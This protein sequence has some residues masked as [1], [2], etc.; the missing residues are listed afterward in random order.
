MTEPS[1]GRLLRE[2]R[3]RRA[4]SQDDVARA[5]ARLSWQLDQRAADVTAVLLQVGRGEVARQVL[6]T[7]INGLEPAAV[8][9]RTVFLA[10][11]AGSHLIG[12]E[13]DV[14][15][16]CSIAGDVATAL[17]HAGYATGTE[18]RHA[19]RADLRPWDAHPAVTVL[20]ERFTALGS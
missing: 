5:L 2:Q 4:L 17:M 11:I 14:E 1:P 19:L 12:A 8:K 20:D 13:P 15:Q 3:T 6:T 7:A 9:Q 16:A 10:D 18:R